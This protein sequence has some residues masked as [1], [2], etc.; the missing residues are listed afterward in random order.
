M[1]CE[2]VVV[3]LPEIPVGSATVVD[4]VVAVSV[5]DTPFQFAGVELA[6]KTD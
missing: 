4:V 1:F 3:M 2:D 5:D 6:L